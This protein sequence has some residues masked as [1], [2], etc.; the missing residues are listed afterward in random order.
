MAY[1]DSSFLRYLKTCE[2]NSPRQVRWVSLIESYDVKIA[3][4]HG[5]TN[6][7]AY[8]LSRPRGDLNQLLPVDNMEDWTQQ[9]MTL[10]TPIAGHAP[11]KPNQPRANTSFHHGNWWLDDRII[12]PRP[13]Q[14]EVV[15]SCH[16]AITAGNWGSCKTLQILQRRYGF[17][18]MKEFVD[19]HIRTC[20]TCQ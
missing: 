11:W 3:H 10:D 6:T 9:Y 18:D 12:V 5:I 14:E 7:A 1:T 17:D 4:I 15:G 19:H 16:D 13:R 8:S 20:H 2:L